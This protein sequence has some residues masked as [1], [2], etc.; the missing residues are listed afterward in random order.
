MYIQVCVTVINAIHILSPSS[1]FTESK[2][3]YPGSVTLYSQLYISTGVWLS[4]SQPSGF[5]LINP[6]AHLVICPAEMHLNPKI[7]NTINP[8]A[9]P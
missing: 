7:P 4:T 5:D 9:K 6:R 8:K 1:M 2:E 3:A